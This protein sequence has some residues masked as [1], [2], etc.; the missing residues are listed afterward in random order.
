MAWRPGIGMTWIVGLCLLATLGCS[1]ARPISSGTERFDRDY[2]EWNAILARYATPDGFNYSGLR[3]HR[4]L[5]DQALAAMGAVSRHDFD[6]WPADQ[7]LAFLINAHNAHAIDRAL[8]HYPMASIETRRLWGSTLDVRD[9]PLLGRWWSLRELAKEVLSRA[10][11]I[12]AIFLLNWAETGCAPLPPVAIVE[13]NIPDLLDR[14]A[15]RFLADPR[16]C[17]FDY[18][19]RVMRLSRLIKDNK[20]GIERD[21]TTLWVFLQRN[22][23]PDQASQLALNRPRVHWLGFDATLNDARRP[24]AGETPLAGVAG[25]NDRGASAMA[26]SASTDKSTRKKSEKTAQKTNDAKPKKPKKT[27][28]MKF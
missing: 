13:R 25:A 17:Q 10:P 9:V 22:L 21:F 15:R 28:K 24:V 8:K 6:A 11:D 12:R 4:D 3:Q 1:H 18:D 19:R 5:L 2:P 27:K 14:Q 16:N 26:S 20:G 7:R 23:P